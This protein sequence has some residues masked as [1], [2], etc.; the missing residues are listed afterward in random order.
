MPPEA[1]ASD[2]ELDALLGQGGL[3]GGNGNGVTPVPVPPVITEDEALDDWAYNAMVTHKLDGLVLEME[4]L[5]HAQT[6]AE[7]RL[8]RDPQAK[9][10]AAI[11]RVAK[12]HG[13]PDPLLREQAKKGG[14]ADRSDGAHEQWLAPMT[15]AEWAA[16]SPEIPDYV[17]EPW[18][19][20]GYITDIVGREKGGKSTFVANACASLATGRPFLGYKV[21]Q[22]P[23]VY[24]YESSHQAWRHLMADGGLLAC[25]HVYAH[26]WPM[27]PPPTR[28][29]DWDGLCG[30][31]GELVD[32]VG[33]GLVVL[34]ILPTWARLASD[35]ENDP[36]VARTVMEALRLMAV[37]H[38]VAV[39]TVR[40]TRKG[41]DEDH[42][43]GS[44]GTGAWIGAVDISMGYRRPSDGATK[45][46]HPNRRIV[47]SIGRSVLPPEL[48][49]DFDPE[50]HRLTSAGT[51]DLAERRDIRSWL[52]DS[53]PATLAEAIDG[54]WSRTKIR[55]RAHDDGGYAVNRVTPALDALVNEGLARQ[56]RATGK[57]GTPATFYTLMTDDL[58]LL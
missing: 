34:D 6:L 41:S 15:A 49:V 8:V 37:G 29:L 46:E 40:H 55:E 2:P 53:L 43:E 21:E 57:G 9:C 23:V 35:A 14:D 17:L 31:I 39:W 38:N 56:H 18:L 26:L 51:P 16:F 44:R 54:G 7:H 13:I 10:R 58:E 32:R 45:R 4:L 11:E 33:A 47:S 42:V 25:E 48:L 27:L 30:W 12:R 3:A 5:K 24:L 22:A 28:A 36:G 50:T 1:S 20:R 52:L 19:V